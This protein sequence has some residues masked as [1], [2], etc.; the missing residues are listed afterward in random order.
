MRRNDAI[1]LAVQALNAQLQQID[2]Y[3][4]GRKSGMLRAQIKA[5]IATLNDMKEPPIGS[6]L[7]PLAQAGNNDEADV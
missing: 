5:A 1:K 2:E 7:L 4:H 3:S 6:M